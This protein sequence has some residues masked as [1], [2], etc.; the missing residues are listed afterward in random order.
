MESLPISLFSARILEGGDREESERKKG[1]VPMRLD[2]H[3]KIMERNSVIIFCAD[4][5]IG[6]GSYLNGHGYSFVRNG[7]NEVKG[8]L[9]R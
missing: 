6:D 8:K 1:S 2:R 9:S 3:G 4:P 5:F 7:Y